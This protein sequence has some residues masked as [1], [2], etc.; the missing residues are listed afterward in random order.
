MKKSYI[1]PTITIVEIKVKN[2]IASSPLLD[3]TNAAIQEYGMDVKGYNY[4]G[5][6]GSI[7]WDDDWSN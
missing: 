5:R 2:I 1:N 6:S 3:D 4:N 7:S